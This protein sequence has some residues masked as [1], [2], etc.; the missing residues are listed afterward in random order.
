MKRKM[1]FIL[2]M[3]IMGAGLAFFWHT[4]Q[5]KAPGGKGESTTTK[6]TNNAAGQHTEQQP[7]FNTAQYSLED[8]TSMWVVVNK[9]RPLNP[10]NYAPALT[11]PNI[12]LAATTDMEKHVGAAMAPHL[13][14]LVAAAKKDGILLNLQSGYRSYSFQVALYNRYVSEQGKAVADTQSARPGH[15]EHQTGW[16]ADLGTPDKPAC[17]VEEC[18]GDTAAGKWLA[19]N[20]YKY[21]FIIRYPKDKQGTTGYIYEPWHV[22]YVGTDLATEMHNKGVTTLEEFFGL[23]AAPDYS[24]E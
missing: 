11:I 16:A 6:S 18:F 9:Q 1:I 17:D 15:S 7:S 20:S 22:R 14:S 5:S 19:D 2:I 23:P 21:G 10:V 8:P 13:E 24:Q 3:G 12:P 4:Q